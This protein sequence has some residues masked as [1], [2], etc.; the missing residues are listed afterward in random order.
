M[1]HHAIVTDGQRITKLLN[2]NEPKHFIDLIYI[3]TLLKDF[4]GG[5]RN[6]TEKLTWSFIDNIKTLG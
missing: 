5:F 4:F 3:V 1:G 6:S 2:A